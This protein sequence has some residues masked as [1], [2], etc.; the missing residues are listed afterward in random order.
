MTIDVFEDF[1]S[2]ASLAFEQAVGA[3]LDTI[4]TTS[5]R[6]VRYHM[7]AI[8]D[9]SS[10]GNRYSARAANAAICA[11]D[12]STID[13]RQVPPATCSAATATAT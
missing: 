8:Y 10:K 4:A 1:Q 12:I 9:A 5:T 11:S 7:V 13:F 3:D 6:Q 2:T